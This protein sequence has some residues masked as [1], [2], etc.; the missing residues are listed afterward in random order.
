[1]KFFFFFFWYKCDARTGGLTFQCNSVLCKL[2]YIFVYFLNKL[3][4]VLIKKN[5]FF[6]MEWYFIYI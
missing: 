1:M 6:Y 3:Q 5:I 4:V 2:E